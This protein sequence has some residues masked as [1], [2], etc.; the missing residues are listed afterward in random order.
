MKKP[1][2]YLFVITLTWLA[3]VRPAAALPFI[4]FTQ[5]TNGEQIVTFASLAGTVQSGG[6]TI[7]RAAF[8]IY[9]QSIG[10][11]WNGTNFQGSQVTLSVTLTGTN[12]V[13][14][15]SVALPQPC[16]GQN[17]QLQAT[18][19][20]T[21]LTFFNTNITVQADSIPP[22][23]TFATLFEGQIVS[24]L[25]TLGGSVT[26]NF[27]LVASVVFSIH[28]Q[29]ANGG[30]GRWWNGTNF[31]STLATLP[32]SVA[33]TS[34]SPFA[35]L[36]LPALNS[37]QSYDLTI[38]ATDTTSN[39]SS[40]T[41]TVT[42]V[43]TV[44]SWDPGQTPAGTV[45]LARPNTN[46]GNYWF[47][48]IPQTPAVGVWRTALDVLGGRAG[49][50]MRQNSPPST[51]NGGF[52]FGSANVG[53]N[54]FVVDAS[55]Y[56]PGQNWYI[57]VNASTNAQWNL[58][59][60]DAF[61]YNLGSLATN[62]ASSTNASIGAEGMI[63]YQTTIPST[64]LAW[65]LWLNGA[66][67]QAYVKKSAAPT[68]DPQWY[69]L[70]Q[71][72]QM[73]VAP[74]YLANGSYFIGV[75]GSPGTA[76]NLDSRQQPVLPLPFSSLTNLVV[77]ATNFPY[78]TFQVQVPVQQ[79]AWQLNLTPTSGNPSI[80]VRRDLVPS[81]F[82]NDAFSETPSTVG[83]S[84]SL[85]P[86]PPNSA[87]GTPGL[88][89]GTWYVTIYSTG[90]YTCAFTNA[91]PVITPESYVFQA[92]NDDPNRVGWRFYV[93]TN[94]SQQLGSLGWALSLSNQAPGSEIAIRRNAVPGQWNYRNT[95]D[96]YPST[97]LGYVDISSIYGLLQQ[98]GHQADIWYIGV[99]TPTQALGSFV[100]NGNLLTGRPM[101]F[102]GAGSSVSVANQPPGQWG[103]FQVTVPSDPNLLG[104]DV[105][106]VG[107][108]NG[109]P[110][111]VVSR[112]TLPTGL[113]TG[114][115]WTGP[116]GVPGDS[117][118]WPSGAQWLN[119]DWTRC[120]I[121]PM[122]AMGMGNPLQPG[123]Y[124]IGVQDPNNTNSYT[125]QSRGI[126]TGY[127]IAVRNLAFSGSATNT[128]LSVAQGDYYQ[129]VVPS[130]MPDWKL[131]LQ[132]VLGRV[133]LK[134][135][136]NYL[137]NS[138]SGLYGYPDGYEP[139]GGVLMMKPGDEQWV[140]LPQNN[141][142]V[143]EGTN[144]TAGSTY[145]VLVASQGQNLTNGNCWG[146][147]TASYRLNSGIEP[148]TVLPD[149]L[150]YSNALSLTNAQAGGQMKFYQFNVPAGIASLEVTLANVVGN[151]VMYMNQGDTLV[152][153]W[154][155]GWGP[156]YMTLYDSYG[157]FGGTNFQS[158]NGT[159]WDHATLLTVP[160]PQPGAYSV[161]VYG[162]DNGSG[163]YPDASYVLQVR[164]KPPPL[165]AF[166]GGTF[167][168]TNQA[169]GI[170]QYF[171]INVPA[172]P[173]LLGWDVR[174]EGV[175]NG[176][177]QMVVSRDTLPTGL[178]TGGGWTGPY[179][180]PGDSTN[181]PSGAQWLNQDWTRCNLTPMLAMGM[182]NPLQP[183]TYYIGVQ[184]PNNTNSYTLQSRG[185]GTGY[186]IAVR[187]LAFNG[188][189]TN[190]S[191]SVA[192]G[193]YY[194]VVAPAN[195]PDWKLHLHA[196]LGEVLLKVEENYLPN[197]GSGLY[198][199]P[200]GYEP[201]GGVLMMKP[202]DEQWT[203]LPQN[204]GSVTEGTNL[205]A[206]STY[207]VLVA[208]QGQNPIICNGPGS[209]W[210]TGI[211][212]Y[213]LNSGIEPVTV[214]PDTLSYSNALTVT[215]AQAGGEMKFYEF[216]VPAGIASLEVTLA[217]VLG[218][219]VIYM[220][221]GD[222]LV[223]TWWT[224][225]GPYYMTLYDSYGNF[226]G[227][228]FQSQNGTFWDHATL[229]TVPNPQPGVY[230]VSVY[231]ADN[232][233]GTY[234]DASYVLQVQAKPP[235]LVSFDGGTFAV[236]NQAPGVWQYFQIN[237][238]ADP[239]LL[240][241]DVRL[242]G[243]SNGNPQM[244]VS[245]DT[246]PTGLNT[247]GGW[248]GP[249]GVPGDSTNWPSGAQWLNQDWTRC[250][251]APMLAVGMGNPLQ[252]GTYYIGV[253]DPN[254]TNSYT[255]QSRGI[256]TGYTIP[257]PNL[258]FN[259][260]ATNT[261]LSVAQGD[262]YRLVV[263]S[264]MPDWKLQLQAVLGR[265]LLKVEEN[266]LPNSGSGLYGYPDGY[267][268][269]G[270]VLMMKPGD[271]QWT[272]LPQNNGSVT[273][274][275]NLTVGSTYYVLVASQGQNLTNGNCWGTGSASYRLNSGI[276]PVTVLPDTLSYS[277]ALS[278]TNAQAGGQM[279]FYQFNVPAGIASLEV[280]LANVVG[281]PVMYM[282][283]GDDLV[284]TWWTG[285]GPYYM[286]L[287]DSY[288]NFGGTNFQSQNGT[289][290]DHATLLTVPNPQPGAYS[291]S[292]YGA[293]DGS[294]TY[295]NGS[296]QLEVR[297]R[298]APQL[299][300]SPDFD[301]GSLT[302]V[303][304]GLLADS[305]SDFYEV[306]VPASAA[307][308][309]VLG[310]KLDLTVSN[311]TP[312]LRVRQNLLP[313]DNGADGTSPFNVVTATI[314]P[315]YLQPGTWYVQVKA[316]GSTAFSLTSSVITTNTL[317]HPLWVMPPIGQTNVAPGL[318][319]PTI[320]DSGVDTN[321][322]P[323]PGDQGIDL[324]QGEFDY[325]AVIVPTN[326]AALLR[327]ELQAIS[328]NP[329][330]YL[331]T[332]AAPTLAHN[333]SGNGGTIYDR[334]LTGGTTEYANWVPLNARTYA[335]VLT[336]GVW[337]I[338]VQ[339][340]G[341]G[342]ARYRLQ[343]SCGNS[344]SNG[345]VQDLAL[346]GG[347]FTNQ[348]LNGGDWR[349]YRLQIPDPAPANLAVTFSRS[350]GS[351]RMF[352]RDTSPPGDGN[353]PADFSNSGYNP[354]PWYYWQ[355]QDLES[356]AG[357]G[358]NEG[359]YPRFDAPGAYNLT[360]PPLRP[361]DVYYLG[362]WSPVDTTFSVSSSTNGGAI[363]ITNT[364]A[365]LGGSI[366]ASIPAN[367]T[368][369]YRMG[370]PPSATR[371]LFNASNSAD[372]VFSL[373]QGTIAL[374][375]GPAHWTSYL[376]NNPANGNQANVSF[377]QVLDT[378]NNWPWLP[379]FT[380]Y[381]TITNTSAAPEDF[382]LT[383]GVPADL[384]AYAF[385]AP[386]NVTSSSPNPI[387]QVEWGVTNRGPASASGGWYDVVWFSTN[388]V[389]DANSIALGYFWINQTVLSGGT[390]WQTNSVTLPMASSGTYTLFVQVD[391]NNS[392]YEA[393]LADKVSPGVTGTFTLS[394]P[395]PVLSSISLSGTDLVINGSNGVMGGTYKVSMSTTLALPLSQWT[396]VSTNVLS[397]TGNFTITATN[398]VNTNVP[399]RFFSL[400]LLQ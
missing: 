367:G 69:E 148:V 98:P 229:L 302:N 358:K 4:N 223:G 252:P 314:V 266:Y 257:V 184:D 123:T 253:Q 313:D 90:P 342:N 305:E 244:V 170:W 328:G 9:N 70:T 112:D 45:V 222:T 153:T 162:A 173:N 195:V 16:C 260:S 139:Y 55:Q 208:S 323:L 309:P 12:W 107:V 308:A 220:N 167:A 310:W 348:N 203:L 373:E 394:P 31:Q 74:P 398:A 1:K 282:N 301:S 207:Y 127:T 145:Y 141:G 347:G 175:S 304:S 237:V 102:D 38:I 151:P 178:N 60:G 91:N 51:N 212:S 105:R 174:L 118:N 196:V 121:T 280:K 332:G 93:L 245:R 155:T 269:Y 233:S 258:T 35:G 259:G 378:P 316:S 295:P 77:V 272:L 395:Q 186:T 205:T 251:L 337:V 368:L 190:T 73:L 352:V 89:D 344:T 21:D 194:R 311:G 198:G 325:Y 7:Q 172:D 58:V 397:T 359:P 279:K 213:T 356:W 326:N 181:W 265:V 159:L 25:S 59:T 283:Q 292:V 137:P 201:Y 239:N 109:N 300:V 274:G 289:L 399:R 117:T 327:T 164:A 129:L 225:W 376:Y 250:N 346:N 377:D 183:G 339:A 391:V 191:L 32:G 18:V 214:L 364:L 142:Y 71:A 79:I 92:T 365:F 278:L 140:L 54:G 336:N 218:N 382:T 330:L 349:Y 163:T 255:L 371:I 240:G 306:I 247:G 5:P 41:I 345:V 110:Q 353:N 103:F 287:Y 263:P 126:G 36:V 80:A 338:A 249:Y 6:G 286:T 393:T 157:N 116:Y 317:K 76:I 321:G 122:L 75:S 99:Y 161:S 49:V 149:T 294:G 169:P 48:I 43:M 334:S 146:T 235:P 224:G 10:Q 33:G 166:D 20:N 297:A 261:S 202:G 64:T 372:I 180:V 262:Y 256:G 87:P 187:N 67:N 40:L 340:G 147:G 72:G 56:Q 158:Q 24:N 231:G 329:N 30:A 193:D 388:G 189:A 44:L 96:Y 39:S 350:L 322:T 307:G 120:N 143:T 264:N 57:L 215:N 396:P 136:E 23:A 19:T 275:T 248:T 290:W 26:D 66:P 125:L 234:P 171:Q 68:P 291:V 374:A 386:T 296:Y 42:N 361:G 168:V 124:Y 380:Y 101:P 211:A 82:R 375:S 119:Q 276:E 335:G 62:G 111:M 63:F 354:G 281:N 383:M 65:Q 78:V 268:P 13:P 133:L 209:G 312:S 285:W 199:Y 241:W 200:D 27:G 46:G 318:A 387:I 81:E 138:G 115:G 319:L 293:D 106:L 28:E 86:P 226:G 324:K 2:L 389:L 192:Q 52:A 152:G 381:L 315:P 341:N 97:S 17:Y 333:V 362:F 100:L 11:W 104:W 206:G 227:T 34:W 210:G 3:C 267:E 134:V 242:V 216:N 88:S 390:Y 221:Q 128:S 156:Y 114:G 61:V 270:G 130:N 303:A 370:V 271:E 84:V 85:V 357:D 131:Q 299:S 219:P 385:T 53:S 15:A 179:G 144:L 83:A 177:P 298:P 277:N 217:N 360:T 400:L 94:I 113:N 230:S 185:I 273:E 150:S 108:S 228:N 95:D 232:G 392:I 366:A 50:Y 132:S 135:E 369:Q 379:G 14:A 363:N 37:G 204:N 154:W 331:R 165:V 351:A 22:V 284:G 188:S 355:N 29:D 160:N 254:N 343:L 320:G 8:S 243:V 197:S 288:G 47:Q 246:L 176:N 238:P 384:A 182:G 236:T